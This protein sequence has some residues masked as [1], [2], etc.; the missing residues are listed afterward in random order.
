MPVDNTLVGSRK[1]VKRIGYMLR[2]Y[3][4]FS[5][6]FVA[7]EIAELERQGVDIG[8]LSLKAPTDGVFHEAACR[9]KARAHYL[10]E[11]YHGRLRKISAAQLRWLRR[12]WRNYLDAGSVVRADTK[13][14]WF[15]LCRAVDVLRWVKKNRVDH[16][17][18][19]FGTSEATVALVANILGGLSYSLTLHAFDIF[20]DNVDRALL[21]RKINHSRF[22][23]TVSEFNRRFMVENL[24]GVDPDKIRVNYNG[25]DLDR[26]A[27]KL[28]RSESPSI[29]GLGRLIEKK[30]FIHMIRAVRQLR[31]RGMPVLC[32]IGGS[33][34]Q[35]GRLR[36]EIEVLGLED[37]VELLGSIAEAE[38][39][40]LMQRSSCFV[41]PCVRAKDGN[42]DALPTVLLE[43]LASGCPVVTT[44]LSGNPEII[45]HNKTGMLVE[46]GNERELTEAIHEMLSDRTCA[47]RLA[48]AGQR[49]VQRRFNIRHNVARHREWLL[50]TV[51]PQ[52]GNG[53]I[54]R[55]VASAADAA[56]SALS[57]AY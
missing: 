9:V 4:R 50:E 43:A 5:Q 34:P 38:V 57:E 18:V 33:G 42:V 45:E 13:S 35:E 36:R 26:F 10:P 19:H 52:R 16:V 31:D 11:T 3:P 2:M 14:E 22:T 24:T 56:R 25:I 8:I 6:T 37:C 29:F 27:R 15:D 40:E 23:V 47:L 44:R 20:R 46:P 28:P 12:G 48:E 55:V 49:H 53:R 30:G 54:R 21:A 1:R 7:N 32:R 17:H 41:L 39:R 51:E